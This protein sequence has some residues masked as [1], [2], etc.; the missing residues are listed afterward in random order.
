M[1]NLFLFIFL[2]LGASAYAQNN[3]YMPQVFFDK[4][5][6]QDMLAI[7][8]ST[9]EGV[10]YT[11]QYTDSKKQNAPEG[12]LVTLYPLTPYFEEFLKLRTQKESKTNKVYLSEEAFKYRIEVKTDSYGR[13]KFEKLKPGKYYIESIVPYIGVGHYSE[14]TGTTTTYNGYGTAIASAPYY[15]RF[16]YNFD[17]ASRETKIVEIKNDGE[18]LDIKLYK[19][20]ISFKNLLK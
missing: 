5:Q 13:F 16:S 3:T 1:K 7:G 17:A 10:A 12:T 9:I 2:L 20:K 18:F 11:R 4:Q 14:Q 19:S 8:T 15:E 6:A